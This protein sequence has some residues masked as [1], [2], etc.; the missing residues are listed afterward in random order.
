MTPER[1]LF[2]SIAVQA[3]EDFKNAT[4]QRE[5]ERILN[6]V[7]SDWFFEICSYAEIHRDKIVAHLLTI[8][9]KKRRNEYV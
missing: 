6:E 4:T 2:I 5:R 3:V 8:P 7:K 9:S 1:R